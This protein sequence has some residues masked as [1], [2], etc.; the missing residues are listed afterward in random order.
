MFKVKP[1]LHP[2]RFLIKKLDPL[3][4][5]S[6]F[7][8]FN[9]GIKYLNVRIFLISMKKKDYKDIQLNLTLNN[10]VF[11][12]IFL[13][14]INISLKYYNFNYLIKG[15]ENKIHSICNLKYCGQ[16]FFVYNDLQKNNH[17]EKILCIQ[18]PKRKIGNRIL[19]LLAKELLFFNI[20]TL[21]FSSISNS[22]DNDLKKILDNEECLNLSCFL[23]NLNLIF[24]P[25]N[26]KKFVTNEKEIYFMSVFL[27]ELKQINQI[28]LYKKKL[29]YWFEFSNQGKNQILNNVTISTEIK[30][31]I[32]SKKMFLNNLIHI[33][34]LNSVLNFK[35]FVKIKHIIEWVSKEITKGLIENDQT[36]QKPTSLDG[37]FYIY[38]NIKNFN[39]N[40]NTTF[41]N[42]NFEILETEFFN[43][44]SK[45]DG[46]K[47]L[48]KWA[49]KTIGLDSNFNKLFYRFINSIFKKNEKNFTFGIDCS[50][51]NFLI[52][53]YFHSQKIKDN[54][55]YCVDR[56]KLNKS[57][58]IEIF[59]FKKYSFSLGR[60]LNYSKF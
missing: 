10:E 16:E 33:L 8:F 4:S 49:E 42:C 24:C 6:T 53:N 14:N 37:F 19:N 52:F 36:F 38:K 51:R 11:S 54:L 45:Y 25:R 9:L 5:I 27:L 29:K 30:K 60:S 44:L 3:I 46:G 13:S 58:N 35:N 50:C 18:K 57:N 22:R 31:K 39:I 59:D 17:V 2:K 7:F 48:E 20:N 40:L 12:K 41:L 47:I 1:S 43:F 21:I 26:R 15:V 56:F 28:G 32:F 34:N 55:L 23:E